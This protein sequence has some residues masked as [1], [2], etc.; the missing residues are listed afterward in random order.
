MLH[1]VNRSPF[2]STAFTDCLKI[3]Q[4]ND[5]LLLIEDA[6]LAATGKFRQRLE[7][8][9]QQGLQIA[10]LKDDIIAR[11]LEE[12]VAALTIIGYLDFVTL[13]EQHYPCITWN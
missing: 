4:P 6:V 2:I 1:I 11:G 9:Q 12:K 3:V 7:Q 8:L 10:L 5:A 13:T